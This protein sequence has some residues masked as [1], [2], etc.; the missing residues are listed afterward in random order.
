MDISTEA[1]WK[2]YQHFLK[3]GRLPARA[4]PAQRPDEVRRLRVH[5][6]DPARGARRQPAASA[7][8]WPSPARPASRPPTPTAASTARFKA[9]FNDAGVAV[10]T[11][12]EPGGEPEP[13]RYSL[14]LENVSDNTIDLYE[15]VT[16]QPLAARRRR[17]RALRL[18]PGALR[19]RSRSRRSTSSSGSSSRTAYG[20]QRGR[21][22]RHHGGVPARRR[23]LRHR[24][25]F[26]NAYEWPPPRPPSR[27]STSSTSAQASAATATSACSR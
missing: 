7:A 9:H 3:L 6:R 8:C 16:G 20:P 1:G 14:L 23:P 21:A 2:A 5:R 10:T 13:T 22:A 15:H 24:L 26:N 17:H 25:G 19:R 27:R 12:T 11:H 4:R 18:H